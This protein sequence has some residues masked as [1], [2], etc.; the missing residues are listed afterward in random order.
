MK[1]EAF[2]IGKLIQPDRLPPCFAQTD[3]Y[4]F[5]KKKISS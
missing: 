2:N 4:Q 1:K 5:I 3:N